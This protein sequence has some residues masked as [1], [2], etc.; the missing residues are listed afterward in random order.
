MKFYPYTY[1]NTE[2]IKQNYKISYPTILKRLSSFFVKKVALLGEDGRRYIYIL[3]P[4]I[5]EILKLLK[6]YDSKSFVKD[7]LELY[8]KLEK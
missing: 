3:R 2:Y 4:E 8:L 6:K 1:I 5:I 7:F